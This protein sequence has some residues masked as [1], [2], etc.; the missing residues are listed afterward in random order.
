MALPRLRP[1]YAAR[2]RA[3]AAQAR[4][5]VETL[6][7]RPLISV[8]MPAYQTPPRYLA[9]AIDSVRRQHYPDWE[10]CIADDGSTRSSTLRAL[11]RAA[12]SDPRIRV[13]HLE[14]NQ[15]I[16]A[17]TNAALEL[18][19]GE[20]VAFLDH[21][22]ALTPDAL[23]EIASAFSEHGCDV[24]YSDSDKITPRGRRTAPF[25]KPDWSPVYALGAMYIGHLLAVRRSLVEAVGGLDS[26]FDTIQDFELLLRLSERTQR[27]HHVRR[28]L[29]HWRAIPG[30]IAAGTDEKDGVPELQA[31][32]VNAHLRRRGTP[33]QA[34]PHPTIP[35]RTRLRPQPADRPAV[36]VVV[37][38]R[39]QGEM[40]R[41]CLAAVSERTRYPELELIAVEGP[42]AERE[43]GDLP[44]AAS[45]RYEGHSFRPARM[46]SLG[47]ECAGGE[48]LIFL[49]EDTEVLEP[50]WVDQLVML[51][52]LPGVGTAGPVL[53]RPN[54]R[55]QAAGYAVGL[56]EPAAAALQGSPDDGDGYYGNLACA[57]E[58]AAVSMDCMVIRSSVF[59]ELGGFDPDF[60]RQFH[61]L[62]LCME[63]GSRG[64]SSVCSPYP[65]TFTHRS[66][67]VR[68]RDFDVI[69][70][71]LFA[72]RRYEALRSGD[73]YFNPGF[74]R[75]RAD[76]T[77]ATRSMAIAGGIR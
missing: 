17:A 16:S 60:S 54:G 59:S 52:G 30:S 74:V 53:S 15:G 48:Y 5:T 69:D 26:A 63:L 70:R 22:D 9:E 1:P 45:V 47:A 24:A 77:P 21:D 61:D 62:D 55:V 28:I 75:G 36:S 25:L 10:L 32:A 76:Y 58:V 67:A 44:G 41:R 11:G 12:S 39:G 37:P 42:W 33:A 29:Y 68:R 35:H 18:C 4:A 8:V 71:A 64:L 14:R 19:R 72:E 57:R 20:L 40:L 66:N 50:D 49:D 23:L 43:P 56:R 31:R 38:A 3:G 6:A 7:A 27:I 2:R 34:E 46:A 65:R 51:S 73:P 13:R